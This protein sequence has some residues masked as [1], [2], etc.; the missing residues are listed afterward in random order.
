MKRFFVMQTRKGA[1][2]NDLQQHPTITLNLFT[3]FSVCFIQ[4]IVRG[5]GWGIVVN[6][7]FSW[8]A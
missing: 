3:H 8:A 7:S 6:Y 1:K 4:R 5:Q 2:P